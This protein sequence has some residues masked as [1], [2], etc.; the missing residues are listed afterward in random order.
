MC[1]HRRAPRARRR[2]RQAPPDRS[3]R[4]RHGPPSA[5]G[6]PRW[7]V[8]CPGRH[9]SPRP[10]GRPGRTGSSCLI[11]G[12]LPLGLPYAVAHSR[13]RA[14]IRSGG[15]LAALPRADRGFAPSDPPTPSL[16]RAF[17]LPSAP[18]ARSRRSLALIG[19]L[20][21]GLPYAVAHSRFRAPIRSRGSLAA[22]PRADRGCAPRTPLRRRSLALSRSHPLPRLARGAPSRG[23][24][25]CPSDSPTPSLTRAFALPS[26]PAARSRRSLARIGALPLGLPYAV[27][28]SRFRA[29]IRSGGSLAALPRADRGFAPRTP[30]RRRSLA[31]SRSHPLRR[32][33]RG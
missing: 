5:T 23:S 16:T 28:H 6:V 19:A 2:P 21:L 11:R 10:A 1:V 3:P 33:A 18:A 20:P 8:R 30:L 13:F 4:A 25:L 15:S 14:P 32:L 29:P 22:L 27:A 9:R 17:A 26:A 7:R 24:G 31:L 12:A